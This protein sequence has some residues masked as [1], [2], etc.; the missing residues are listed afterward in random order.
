MEKRPISNKMQSGP[1]ADKKKKSIVSV[2]SFK[3]S[4]KSKKHGGKIGKK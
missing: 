2:K 3:G 4:T 1:E